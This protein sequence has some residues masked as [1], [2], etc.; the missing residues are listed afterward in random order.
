MMRAKMKI[1]LHTTLA[2][3]GIAALMMFMIWLTYY[4]WIECRI[5]HEFWYCFQTLG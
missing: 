2:V 5:D 3:I 1:F 4:N